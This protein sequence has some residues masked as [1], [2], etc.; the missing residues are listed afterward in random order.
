MLAPTLTT[1]R[2]ILQAHE[3]DDLDACVRLWQDQ[4]GPNQGNWQ[5]RLPPAV[6]AAPNLLGAATGYCA[7]LQTELRRSWVLNPCTLSLE[8][9]AE[10]QRRAVNDALLAAPDLRD[11]TLPALTP[12]EA[13]LLRRLKHAAGTS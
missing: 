2:L 3:P 11:R 7:A 8:D 13:Q 4:T 6:T 12:E 1:D 10:I 5:R 9:A